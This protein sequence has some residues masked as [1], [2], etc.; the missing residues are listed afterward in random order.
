MS[1]I[2]LPGTAQPY[3]ANITTP[4]WMISGMEKVMQFYVDRNLRLDTVSAEMMP[5]PIE[6]K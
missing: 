6:G 3:S 2:I 4:N 5:N 1:S